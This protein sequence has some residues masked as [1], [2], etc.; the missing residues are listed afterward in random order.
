MFE[1]LL[2]V[3]NNGVGVNVFT[4][5]GSNIKNSTAVGKMIVMTTEEQIV[6]EC[7]KELFYK[8]VEKIAGIVWERPIIIAVEGIN[9][10]N[11]RIFWDRMLKEY[12][13]I[14]FGGGHISQPLVQILGM[15]HFNV[16][17]IDDRP[18]FANQARFPLAKKV[19]CQNFSDS[20]DQ[21][22]IDQDTAVIIVTRGHRYDLDC[23]RATIG[24]DTGYW[25]MIGSKRR[26]REIINLLKEEGAPEESLRHLR[27]PI[28][29]DIKAETPEEIAVSIAAEVICV[30]RGACS[31]PS[32][33][34]RESM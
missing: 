13:A 30:F 22:T 25:G 11:Y 32:N 5:I 31:I 3:S 8:I 15:L 21:L 9:G 20:F 27:S 1:K 4:V 14:V 7:D 18:I 6:E 17:V 12:K 26:V 28:G 16:T 2:S 23:L 33:K 29:L 19:L 24:Y 34:G 10:E